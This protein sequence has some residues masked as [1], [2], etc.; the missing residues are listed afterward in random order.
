M[1]D[2]GADTLSHLFQA[3][4]TTSMVESTEQF[5][6]E[7][8]SHDSA[9][10]LPQDML[11]PDDD[12]QDLSSTDT[13]V[14]QTYDDMLLLIKD[15]EKEKTEAMSEAQEYLEQWQQLQVDHR[16]VVTSLKLKA[17]AAE[18]ELASL[19]MDLSARDR[20]VIKLETHIQ[21]ISSLHQTRQAEQSQ[22]FEYTETM[23]DSD[24]ADGDVIPKLFGQALEEKINILQD[25][26]S[27][28]SDSP[29]S[30]GE[31]EHRL[32]KSA[33]S[34][35]RELISKLNSLQKNDMMRASTPTHIRPPIFNGESPFVSKQVQVYDIDTSAVIS[36]SSINGD[37]AITIGN[38]AKELASNI[39]KASEAEHMF[40]RILADN[41]SEL[42]K[43]HSALEQ[44]QLE[45]EQYSRKNAE[46][47]VCKLIKHY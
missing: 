45:L 9:D 47:K 24:S 17:H 21:N 43:L 46:Q 44:R 28:R 33:L 30:P 40:E 37:L 31:H 27:S 10:L 15:L 26:T 22:R 14:R 5:H 20:Q 19:K 1:A 38:I 25:L 29:Q 39:D 36:S 8:Y 35:S 41:Q 7:S 12:R 16:S 23:S 42:N 2:E 32:L 11:I 13:A 3:H 18:R 4:G 34:S 6:K